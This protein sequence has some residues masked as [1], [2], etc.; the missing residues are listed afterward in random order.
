M[1]YEEKYISD[2]I[3]ILQSHTENKQIKLYSIYIS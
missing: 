2:N 3:Y 1:K